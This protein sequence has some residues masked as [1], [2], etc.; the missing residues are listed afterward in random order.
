M[1]GGGVP[2]AL[3]THL[4]VLTGV[5]GILYIK[6]YMLLLHVA[7]VTLSRHMQPITHHSR[8][9]CVVLLGSID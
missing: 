1:Q 6:A 2:G 7:V 9:Q 4:D 5:G 8:L 3:R